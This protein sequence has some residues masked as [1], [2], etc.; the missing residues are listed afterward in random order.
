[1]GQLCG[2]KAQATSNLIETE[3]EITLPS[4]KSDGD[5]YYDLQ[6]NKYNFLRKIN[7]EDFLYSLV[8]FS[9]ENAT[10]EDDYQKAN[11]NFSMEEP[12]FC[13]LFSNDIFQS[14]LENKILKHK[15]IYAVAGNDEKMTSIFKEGF[16][17]AN[18]GL[19]VK[20]AQNAKEL[21][22]TNADKNSIIKKGD[23]IAYGILFCVGANYVKI[24]ALFNLFK[25]DEILKDSEKLDEFLL[26]LFIIAGYGMANARNKLSKFDEIGGIEKE[27]F[28]ELINTSELKDSQNMVQI[29]KKMLFGQD[30]SVSLNYQNFKDKFELND[31]DNSLAFLLSPSGC[32]YMQQ[33]NNV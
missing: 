1:M 4:Y 21:G 14:F 15:A 2:K 13:E 17:A 30:L 32:R 20:L 11:I 6:E 27:K 12:F 31:K 8:H 16:L 24:R 7:F 28:K 3:K 26:S 5:K 19:G 33:K 9:N 23:A 29:T 18:Y 10:L 22:D 25:K